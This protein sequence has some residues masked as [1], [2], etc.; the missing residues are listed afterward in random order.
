M[1]F[2]S[3]IDGAV[4]RDGHS[5]GLSGAADKRFFGLLR[6]WSDV[7]LVA[8]GTVRTEGYAD[9]RV[10]EASARWRTGHG[11]TAHP[12]FAI[13]TGSLDLDPESPIFTAA[14]ERPI[15][16]TTEAAVA[17]HGAR[18]AGL[19]ELCVTS[20]TEVDG[21]AIASALRSRGL[22]RILC[23]GGPALFGSLLQADVVDELCLTVEPTLEAGD[24]GRIARGRIPSRAMRLV[25][26]LQSE[27]TLLLRY[28]RA[29]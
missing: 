2:V 15:L 8:A 16:F 7:V 18:F 21:S 3:S 20:G 26:V 14:P 9:M 4:T 6:R 11:R 13:V 29:R 27:G 17:R 19:A 24:A 23:E 12:V 10:D 1:N 22:E 28:V 5:G 25:S